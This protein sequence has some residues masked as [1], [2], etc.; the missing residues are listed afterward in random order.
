M[1]I[2]ATFKAVEYG[3]QRPD[4]GGGGRGGGHLG[5]QNKKYSSLYSVIFTSK[6]I[7]TG[8]TSVSVYMLIGV[9]LG[10]FELYAPKALFLGLELRLQQSLL[11]RQA[12]YLFIST[13][14]LIYFEA[15]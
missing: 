12:S 10:V 15:C 9:L 8:F 4:L 11:G 2:G 13:T 1:L 6:K 5:P 14:G 3:H 7:S